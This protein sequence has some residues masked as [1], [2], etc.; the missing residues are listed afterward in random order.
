MD[1]NPFVDDN[2]TPSVD[3]NFG[4][5]GGQKGTKGES[6]EPKDKPKGT[7]GK[8]RQVKATIAKGSQGRIKR[9][10]K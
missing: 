10:Q 1:G 5:K 8:S 9:N 6:K 4:T 2:E 7:E 3:D